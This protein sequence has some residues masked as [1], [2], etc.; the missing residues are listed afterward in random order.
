M[1]RKVY[2]KLYVMIII[3]LFGLKS[4]AQ[5][6]VIPSL[7]PAQLAAL[8]AGPGVTIS[9]AT[10]TGQ[11]IASGSFNALGTNLGLNSG[12]VLTTGNADQSIGPN[13]SDSSTTSFGDPGDIDLESNG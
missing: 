7:T 12:I 5:L 4:H 8:I 10:Y 13:N 6:T 2:L 9:N 3:C 1:L 11:P